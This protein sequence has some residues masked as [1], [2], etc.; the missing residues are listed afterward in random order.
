MESKDDC[1]ESMSEQSLDDIS[2]NPMPNIKNK[3]DDGNLV[4]HTSIES[5]IKGKKKL[6]VN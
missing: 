4:E 5:L 1:K 3:I 6:D 2:S